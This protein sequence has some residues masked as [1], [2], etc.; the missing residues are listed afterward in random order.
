MRET[1]E[2]RSERLLK[3]IQEQK[4]STAEP[5]CCVTPVQAFTLEMIL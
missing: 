2:E 4:Y 3:S 5:I 1:A